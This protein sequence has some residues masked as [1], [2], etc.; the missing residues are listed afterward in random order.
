MTFYCGLILTMGDAGVFTLVLINLTGI[1]TG[2]IFSRSSFTTLIFFLFS[3]FSCRISFFGSFGG[4]GGDFTFIFF[5]FFG[6][7]LETLF[8]CILRC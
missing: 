2:S 3:F 1:L 7:P 8:F 6:G 4:F 5:V